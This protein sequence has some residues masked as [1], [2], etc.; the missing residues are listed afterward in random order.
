MSLFFSAAIITKGL[1]QALSW[2]LIHSIWQGML[3]SMLAAVVVLLTKRK[4]AAL[5]YNLLAGSLLL[6]VITVAFTL[7][8]QIQKIPREGGAQVVNKSS[9]SSTITEMPA[10]SPA[11]GIS[12]S[13]NIVAFLDAYAGWI[14]L[15]WMMVTALRCIQLT[16]GLYGLYR[17]KKVQS[18]TAGDYWNDRIEMLRQ[19]MKIRKPV[20]LLQSGLAKYHRRLVIYRR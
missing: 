3:L 9:L 16:F 17:L 5:R 20:Q 11:A 6:F 13:R 1:V 14:V 8:L 15:A 18:F 10:A 19:Q 7:L 12:I 2:T 4:S